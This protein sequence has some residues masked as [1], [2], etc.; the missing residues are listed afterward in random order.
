M[1]RALSVFG[2]PCFTLINP[3]ALTHI[4][5]AHYEKLSRIRKH[6]LLTFFGIMLK[7]GLNVV[8][9]NY[10]LKQGIATAAV[11]FSF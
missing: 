9:I 1:D 4:K 2:V 7:K 6:H 8:N 10:R 11:D 3:S 5:K